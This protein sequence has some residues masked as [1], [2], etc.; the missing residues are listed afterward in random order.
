[1]KLIRGLYNLP[2]THSGCVLTIGNFDGVHLGHQQLLK[3][4]LQKS[5]AL[6]LPALVMILEPQPNEFFLPKEKV[7]PR[8]YKF[9]EKLSALASCGIENII[10]IRFDKSFAAVPAEQF[11]QSLLLD[12][13][14]TRYL[15]V[16]DDFHFGFKRQG[17]IN[18][19]KQYANSSFEVENAPTFEYEGK[20]LS[21]TRVRDS[22]K[23]GDLITAEKKLGRPYRMCGRIAHGDKLGR[24]LGFPTANI[25]LHRRAVPLSGIFAVK[26]YG[27]GPKLIYGAA[28]VGTRPAVGGTRSLLEVHLL[29]FNQDIYGKH[30]EV[31][32]VH[33]F[34]DEEHYDTL[35]LLAKQI[36]ID[37]QNTRE[38]FYQIT[39][40]DQ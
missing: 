33:K 27:L 25:F 24:K 10:C 1:M 11:I 20:R 5:A 19:L 6:N 30:I 16:G 32:F 22:L 36:A 40:K 15:I 38:F 7:P 31:E 26:V 12:Q 13:L 37:V 21:S 4:L 17:D 28:N 2:K 29:D 23:Q 34:R 8:I 14:K 3:K 35:E 18:L 39:P 9:R